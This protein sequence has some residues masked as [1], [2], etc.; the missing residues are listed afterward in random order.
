MK[1]GRK[2]KRD[3]PDIAESDSVNLLTSINSALDKVNDGYNELVRLNVIKKYRRRYFRL[4]AAIVGIVTFLLAYFQYLERNIES[5]IEAHE[6]MF[7]F[8]INSLESDSEVAR[9]NG[10]KSLE[11]IAFS[12][13]IR[14]PE[15]GALA[16][17]SNFW[18]WV[19][20]K[21]EYIFLERARA[22]FSDY[23]KTKRMNT[24]SNYDLVSSTIMTTGLD[25]MEKESELFDKNALDVELWFL[26]QAD[27][28]KTNCNN[29][30]CD[31]L[32]CSD[33]NFNSS[34]LQSCTFNNA[35]LQKA[36]FRNSNLVWTEFSGA[37]II[38]A[39]FCKSLLNFSRFSKA[40]GDDCD[41]S[42]CEMNSTI[43]DSAS[44]KNAKF[45][46]TD[47]K[48]A[49]M[50]YTNFQGSDM[51]ECLFTNA[52]MDGCILDNCIL[53]GADFRHTDISK[54]KS[55]KG[56]VID[57]IIVKKGQMETLIQKT[58]I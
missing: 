35:Y 13:L 12:K 1:F 55:A 43:L 57:N 38:K 42:G 51:R 17:L 22:V 3:N 21:R 5:R 47:F 27:L 31:G 52:D 14:E 48:G 16:S 33:V 41:F 10:V 53:S 32:Y 8:A 56:A 34:N 4:S 7:L 37:S 23:A 20:N 39:L 49:S 2:S 50:K 30:N 44:F 19:V 46:A 18:N 6:Q 29:K 45:I 15:T 24:K 28:S 11:K 54:I 36:D 25:W 26:N 40:A 58:R 9:A